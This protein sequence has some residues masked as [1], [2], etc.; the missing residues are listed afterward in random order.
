M[1]KALI[2]PQF[3]MSYPSVFTPTAMKQN[4][5]PSDPLFYSVEAIFKKGE[6]LSKLI[7]AC[8]ALLQEKW[9]DKSKRPQGIRSP[10]RDQAEKAKNIDG[11]LVLPP[12]YEEGAIFMR[13]KCKAEFHKP[14]VVNAKVQPILDPAEIYAGCW[15]I[16]QVSPYAYDFNGNRGISFSLIHLQKTK[17]DKP[18]SNRAMP[19]EIFAPVETTDAEPS[20]SVSA[21]DIFS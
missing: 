14:G 4:P 13:F 11:K 3:R 7:A 12:P 9:G 1:S 21:A 15:G 20:P 17:D 10:F 19:E 18:L 2:T 6:D 8:Q 16:A 5:Q